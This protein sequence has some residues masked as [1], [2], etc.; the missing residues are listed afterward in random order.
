MAA[1]SVV[2]VIASL[3]RLSLVAETA[4]I[5]GRLSTE[6]DADA[7][8]ALPEVSVAIA[9]IEWVPFGTVRESQRHAERRRRLR[10]A[11]VG[12]VE[13]KLHGQAAV[14]RRARAD[15]NVAEDGRPVGRSHQRDGWRGRI[16]PPSASAAAK[17]S[18]VV[19]P[20]VQIR[21]I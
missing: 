21:P 20:S 11:E 17:I 6:T 4:E 14:V 19:V 1:T 5:T 7:V 10:R 13:L 3:D 9:V 16:G 8:A 2:H 15:R 18:N 12:A